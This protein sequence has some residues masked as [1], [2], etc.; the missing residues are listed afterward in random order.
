LDQVIDDLLTCMLSGEAR[1]SYQT[2]QSLIHPIHTELLNRPEVALC[3]L[4][5]DQRLNYRDKLCCT[6]DETVQLNNPALDKL[7]ADSHIRMKSSKVLD[8]LHVTES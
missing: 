2:I 7:S 1:I 3:S 8:L 6:F 4:H 5:V